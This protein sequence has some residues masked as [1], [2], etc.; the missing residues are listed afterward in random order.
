M[1]TVKIQ[2]LQHKVTYGPYLSY[3]GPVTCTTLLVKHPF[4][5][6]VYKCVQI[7]SNM[8][9]PS[10]VKHHNAVGVHGPR[11]GPVLQAPDEAAPVHLGVAH[12]EEERRLAHAV[13]RV[14]VGAALQQQVGDL[15]HV[16]AQRRLARVALLFP[17]GDD[18]RVP[19]Q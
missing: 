1:K 5:Q 12:G 11:V 19:I 2:K 15:A 18:L 4:V 3:I 14:D 13:P 17:E 16:A 8:C 7:I 9:L 10:L 6:N